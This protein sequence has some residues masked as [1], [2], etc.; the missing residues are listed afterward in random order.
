[1]SVGWAIVGTGFVA[2]RAVA[3]SVTAG[4]QSE[5]VAVVS[6]DQD[7]ANAFAQKHGGARGYADFDAMLRDPNVQVVFIGTPN[8]LHGQQVIAAARAGKH[9]FC[10]KPLAATLEEA[11]QAA[12]ECARAGVKLGINFQTRHHTC[13]EPIRQLIQSGGIGEIRAIQMEASGG[14]NPLRNWRT[15]PS[16]AILGTTNNLGVHAYDF[17]RYLLASEV[18][19]VMAMFDT[20][21]TGDLE[22]M[23]LVLL[24]FA[25]GTLAYVNANQ[26][27]ANPQADIDIYGTSGRILGKSV[28]RPWM[29]N[30]EVRVIRDRSEMVTQYST[31]DAF[32][33]SVDAFTDAV[34]SD[35]TPNPNGIDGVRSVELTE[36]IGR[37]AR[38]GV[39]VQPRHLVPA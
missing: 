17:L 8:A 37:S 4:K 15:D 7:R 38:E 2:D 1:M 21:R 31:Q 22:S 5:L 26:N 25:N 9:V 11:H 18:N 6:R 13:A 24:R 14:N 20:A 23:A 33:R 27:V 36:A 34:V 30:G 28:T 16:L 10:D 3:P 12:D 19:E 35:T 32:Q 39:A 29:D